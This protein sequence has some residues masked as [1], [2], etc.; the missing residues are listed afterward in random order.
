MSCNFESEGVNTMEF[1]VIIHKYIGEPMHRIILVYTRS[2][3]LEYN[4]SALLQL[5]QWN[6]RFW[7][8][9]F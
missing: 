6:F 4:I 3:L 9:F 5:I 7:F 2:Y 8:F 1:V